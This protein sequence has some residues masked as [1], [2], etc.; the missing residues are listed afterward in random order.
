MGLGVVDHMEAGILLVH[1]VQALGHLVLL[2]AGLGGDGNGVVGLGI[3]DGGQGDDLTCVTQG[4]AGL[5]LFHLADGADV[6]AGELLDLLGLLAPHHVQAAHLLRAAGAGV[7][8]SGVGCDTAGEDLD[9]G[10]LAVLVGDRLEHEGAGHAAGGH[11]E[12]LLGSVGSG[13]LTHIALRGIGQQ[14]HNVVHQHQRA[15][16][17][18]RRAAEHGEQGQ[19]PYALAQALD[20]LH[21]GEVLTG[22]EL[23]HELLAGLGHRLL[24]GVVELGNDLVLA[25]RD[26]D[27]HPFAV[28]HLIGALVQHIDDAGHPLVVIPNG[29]HQGGDLVAEALTQS[30]EGGV[31]VGV[32]LVRLGDID[33]TG[34]IPLF[35]VL[36]GLLQ[37]HAD[38]VLGGADNDSRIGHGQRLHHLAGKVKAARGVQHVDF[39]ALV[40]QGG[41]CG[42]DG[43]LALD[44][45]RVIVADG[46]PVRS[47]PHPVDGAGHIEQALCQRGLAASSVAQQA[48]VSDILYRIAHS[49]F[50][51]LSLEHSGTHGVGSLRPP[52]V[53][54]VG[55]Y[56]VKTPFWQLF[57]WTPWRHIPF[58]ANCIPYIFV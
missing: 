13:P 6:A 24:Q 10:V 41:H 55:Y 34:H 42:G 50:H 37:A 15:H 7:H 56:N 11:S 5:D 36:P 47:L 18:D 29:D 44:L 48:D 19:I 25:L 52:V 32:L 54:S 20:H 2:A 53:R 43:N 1:P 22:E 39:T 17:V 58:K 21:I 57:F 51:S 12:L 46:V 16:G 23:V 33:K 3:G 49:R 35:A 8:Q 28:L 9:K 14:V 27:L 38:P 4:V 26:L 30:V 45:L 40:L 31:I